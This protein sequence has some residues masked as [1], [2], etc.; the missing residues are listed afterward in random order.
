MKNAPYIHLFFLMLLLG[1]ART[2][3][4]PYEESDKTPVDLSRTVNFYL[5]PA[6]KNDPPKCV[7]VFKPPSKGNP[8]FVGRIEKILIRHLSERFPT[9]IGGRMR[10]VR[11]ARYAFDFTVPIDRKDFAESI[12]CGSFLE[13]HILQPKHTYMLVW[14]ELKLGLEARLFRQ[15]DGAELWKARHVARRSDGGVAF[16]PFGLAVNAYDANTFATDGD[17]VESVSEDLVRR[18]IASL[19]NSMNR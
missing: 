11:A 19:P 5:N 13:F 10:D 15:R 18:V 2:E 7:V 12:E 17:V 14:S 4:K 1:C 3:Y 9:V 6:L 16:S 8:K